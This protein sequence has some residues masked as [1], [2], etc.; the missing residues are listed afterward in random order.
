MARLMGSWSAEDERQRRQPVTV[1][2]HWSITRLLVRICTVLT[3]PSLLA[4]APA[5]SAGGCCGVSEPGLSAARDGLPQVVDLTGPHDC[6]PSGLRLSP[7]IREIT[8]LTTT[9]YPPF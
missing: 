6:N 3:P 9:P 4:V 5:R 1:R 2:R 7:D 8:P